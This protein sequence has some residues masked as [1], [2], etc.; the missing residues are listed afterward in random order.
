MDGRGFPEWMALIQH[1]DDPLDRS[2]VE[3]HMLQEC[4]EPCISA[5]YAFEGLEMWRRVLSASIQ[6][7]PSGAGRRVTRS[8]IAPAWL[9]EVYRGTRE[10]TR[11]LLL[12]TRWES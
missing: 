4:Q 5:G 8:P 9:R 3:S 7:P 2:D 10:D 1:T 12:R 6:P 11:R